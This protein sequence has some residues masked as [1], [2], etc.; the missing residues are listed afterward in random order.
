MKHQIKKLD[1]Y[2]VILGLAYCA[3]CFFPL[4]FTGFLLFQEAGRSLLREYKSDSGTAQSLSM[5]SK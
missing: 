5:K 1:H 2:T 4:G 3:F